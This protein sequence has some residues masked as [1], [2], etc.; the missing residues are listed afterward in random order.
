MLRILIVIMIIIVSQPFQR[1]E[2]ENTYFFFE[3]RIHIS[4]HN[5]DTGFV[6][7]PFDFTSVFLFS[8][9]GNTSNQNKPACISDF[10]HDMHQQNRNSNTKISWTHL[11]DNLRISR[12]IFCRCIFSKL[13][14]QSEQ[15]KT[16]T[17]HRSCQ[18][19]CTIIGTQNV[20]SPGVSRL[21]IH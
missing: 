21:Y 13:N 14:I 7:N 4:Y 20:I 17:Q 9:D 6:F 5:H 12:N 2:L 18:T 10:S 15:V 11:Q 3:I 1:T 8:H 16:I 19:G